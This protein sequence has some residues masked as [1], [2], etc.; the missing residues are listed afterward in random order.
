MYRQGITLFKEKIHVNLS[1]A[2]LRIYVHY[3][4]QVLRTVFGNLVQ[5]KSILTLERTPHPPKFIRIRLSQLSVIRKRP[6]GKTPCNPDIFDDWRFWK[7]VLKRIKCLPPY[8]RNFNAANAN[9]KPCGSN[10]KFRKID[11]GKIKS[12]GTKEEIMASLGRPCNDFRVTAN[13]KELS[14]KNGTTNGTEQTSLAVYYESDE[15]LEIRNQRDF[16]GEM[17]W[18]SIGGFVG[19]F[20][21]YGLLQVLLEVLNRMMVCMTPNSLVIK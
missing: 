19:M 4:N 11:D 16:D 20:G 21:G 7:E 18:S 17:L 8:W 5:W 6:D 13:A 12:V 14:A 9:L 10:E 1:L 2:S 15:Y 3:P